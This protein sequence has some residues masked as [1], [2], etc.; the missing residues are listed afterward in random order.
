[1]RN[2]IGKELKKFDDELNVFIENLQKK[3]KN[4]IE[5]EISNTHIDY[6]LTYYSGK[7]EVLI[8]VNFEYELIKKMELINSLI[9]KINKMEIKK[10]RRP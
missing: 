3:E 5:N 4:P 7:F 10:W 2:Y 1:M 6:Y 9:F 8:N